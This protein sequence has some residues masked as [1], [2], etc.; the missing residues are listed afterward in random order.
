MAVASKA[1]EQAGQPTFDEQ[2]ET[3]VE[4]VVEPIQRML[5]AGEIEPHVIVLAVAKVAG[6]LTA[7]FAA[8]GGYDQEEVLG[9]IAEIVRRS[10]RDYHEALAE[11]MPVAGNA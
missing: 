1:G 10:G 6:E 5:Q 3:A 2:L 11:A 7:A 4:Q 8:A 9:D